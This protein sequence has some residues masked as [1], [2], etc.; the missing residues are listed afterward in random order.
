MTRLKLRGQA[1]VQKYTLR[2]ID[3]STVWGL[4]LDSA[5]HSRVIR[6]HFTLDVYTISLSGVVKRMQYFGWKNAVEKKT[7]VKF[8]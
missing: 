3:G 1:V 7:Y 6:N 5:M 8:I 4:H 2:D